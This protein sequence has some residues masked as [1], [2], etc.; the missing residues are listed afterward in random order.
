VYVIF[1]SIPILS[2]EIF[3]LIM[4]KQF[5]FVRQLSSD[6]NNTVIGLVR[7]KS[8]TEKAVAEE[9]AGRSNIH[10]LQADITD[11]EAIKVR[12]K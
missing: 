7:D 8:T 10:I 1:F 2:A 6:S 12:K 9:L 3:G 5:E 11:Y 4:R